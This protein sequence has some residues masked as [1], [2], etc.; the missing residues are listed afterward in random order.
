MSDSRELEAIEAYIKL[1]RYKGADEDSLSKRRDFL[2][3]LLPHIVG[4]EQG[5]LIYREE[6]ESFLDNVEPSAWPFSLAVAREYYYFWVGDIKAIAG[7]K[8]DAYEVEPINWVPK[9]SDLKTLWD[10]VDTVKLETAD[11]WP[12]KAYQS[13]LR[14]EGAAQSLVDIRLKLVKLLL[15]RLKDAPDK[16][17]KIYRIA[18]DAT[19]PLFYKKETRRLFYAV[20][21]EFY[22]FW[23]GDPDA[24]D[25]I[26]GDTTGSYV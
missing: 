20:V 5:G 4:K 1:L 11:T 7:F 23:I 22:Y 24:S 2:Q 15:I 14:N 19:V 16:N 18:V 3:N 9:D 8:N 12:L 10:M 25:Y 26:L 21:R 13:A 17:H 6:V